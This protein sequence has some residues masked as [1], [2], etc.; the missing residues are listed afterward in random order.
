MRTVKVYVG[1]NEIKR[2]YSQNTESC[3]IALA[4]RRDGFN[5]SV[6]QSEVWVHNA[7]HDNEDASFPRLPLDAQ[8][9]IARFDNGDHVEPATFEITLPHQIE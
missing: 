4:L 7:N 9:F 8:N 5:V 3:P 1:H 6:G 2:G